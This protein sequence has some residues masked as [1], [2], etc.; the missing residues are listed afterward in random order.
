LGDQPERGKAH[1]VGNGPG[2]M[3]GEVQPLIKGYDGTLKASRPLTKVGPKLKPWL[4]GTAQLQMSSTIAGCQNG[5]PAMPF[6]KQTA[7]STAGTC[8][9]IAHSLRTSA[10]ILPLLGSRHH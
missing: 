4:P 3:A 1:F 10:A 6:P 8:P 5:R 2:Q 9:M 7:A